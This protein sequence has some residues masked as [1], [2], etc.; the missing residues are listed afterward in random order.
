M[1]K[2]RPTEATRP[3]D[4]EASRRST[5]CHCVLELQD[6]KNDGENS[7]SEADDRADEGDAA[8]IEIGDGRRKHVLVVTADGKRIEHGDVYLKH[9]EIEFIVSPDAEFTDATTT[10][11]SKERLNRVEVTQHHSACFITTATVDEG[12][13]LDALRGFRDDVLARSVPGRGLLRIYDAVSPPIAATLARHPTA[14]TTRFVRWLVERCA[15]LANR[16]ATS[17]SLPVRVALSALLVALYVV[18]V[19][20]AAGGHVCIR[21][22][23][24]AAAQ[25]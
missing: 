16:R 9:S 14:R 1:T 12:D 19:C 18:G 15:T 3:P 21:V 11:Y 20:F 8:P 24:R 10:R 5:L 13:V 25:W 6:M 22:T 2:I 23:E 7:T 17:A 4:G